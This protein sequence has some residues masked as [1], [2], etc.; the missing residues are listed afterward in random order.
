MTNPHKGHQAPKRT[1]PIVML[2]HSKANELN[3]QFPGRI[4]LMFG[5]SRLR[6]CGELPV[7]LDNDRFSCWSKGKSWDE[8]AF[9]EM[10]DRVQAQTQPQW[11]V[12][13]DVVGDAVATFREWE[14]WEP[15]LRHRKIPLA[16]AV[17]DGMTPDAVRSSC[18]PDVIFVGGTR[19]W[20][21]RTL[22]NWCREFPHVHVGRVNY[23]RWLWDAQRAGAKSTDGTGWFRG[24]QAQ[25]A[26]LLR[27][28]E[29]SHADM[30]PMQLEM[31]FAGTFEK[32]R[33]DEG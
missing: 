30:G 25:L 22:W 17:Q 14:T 6:P 23:E 1:L 31:E 28:L 20:K 21:R 4:G 2:N 12:V 10:L 29:R 18:E 9:L 3:E 11:V 27:Y 16:L 15:R 5:P 33:N 13:P 32:G 19:Q 26:G 8:V 7:V 24:D